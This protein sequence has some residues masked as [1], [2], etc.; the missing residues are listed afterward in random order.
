MLVL[1][2]VDLMLNR[3]RSATVITNSGCIVDVDCIGPTYLCPLV[4]SEIAAKINCLG[5]IDGLL[6]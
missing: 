4:S 2:V 1:T 3:S 6:V 5:Q